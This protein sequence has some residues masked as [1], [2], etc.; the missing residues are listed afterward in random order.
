MGSALKQT[1]TPFATVGEPAPPVK[2]DAS[3]VNQVERLNAALEGRYVVERELGRG[4]MA[5]VYLA[6]DARHEREVAIKVLLPELSASIGADRFEREIRLAAKLQHPHILGLF[7]SGSANGLL[8]YVMPFVKGE[9]LRDRMDREGQLPVDDAILIILEVADA[10][11]HAHAQGIVHRDIKPENIMLSGGHALVADFGIARAATD[12]GVQKLTQTGMAIGTP[13]YM[14]PEQAGGEDVGPAAD[15]YSLACVLYEMLAGEPPFTGKTPMSIMARHAMEQ[16]PSIRIV[17]SAVS[18]EVEAAIYAGMGK[19]PAD[20]PRTAQ[21]F[22]E[23]IGMPMAMTASL[24]AVTG[25]TGMRRVASGS[26]LLQRRAQARARRPWY[27][28]ASRITAAI[29]LLL[30]L[31]I[32][33]YYAA[34]ARRGPVDENARRVAVLYFTD[35]SKAQDLGSL[36]DGLTEGLINSLG[37]A[38]SITVIS[39]T[40][41]ER[42]RGSELPPDSIARA[43]RAGYLV[44]GDVDREGKNVAVNVRLEDRSG[45]K[46]QAKS[47]RIAESDPLAMRDSLETAVSEL[48]KTT[49]HEEIQL[50][51]ERAGTSKQAAWLELQR[52]EQAR[53]GIAAL[54]T[55]GD[56]AAVNRAVAVTDSI[57]AH[58]E[59]L[60]P[61]WAEPVTRRAW[62]AYQRSRSVGRDPA[63]IRKWVDIATQHAGRALAMDA[64]SPDALEVRGTAKYWSWLSNLETDASKKQALLLDAK[65]DL[66]HATQLNPKQ[67]SAFATL[68]SLYYQVPDATTN[69]AYLAATKAYDADEFL[70]NAN[71]VINR[72]FLG[73]YDLGSFDRADQHC[74]LF[75][76]RFPQDYRSKRCRLFMLSTPRAP[77]LDLTAARRLADSTVAMRAPKDSLLER[78]NTNLLI[79]AAMA[80]ASAQQPA[81]ADSARRVVKASIGDAQVDPNRDLTYLAAFVYAQLGDES[82]AVRMVKEYL[83]ANPQRARSLRDEP[84]WGFKRLEGNAQFRQV[85]GTRG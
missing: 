51:T 83:A 40:G 70:A 23:I 42:F 4:G 36:A 67:A 29:T 39:R 75:V 16:V 17:R 27:T 85:I 80:R 37:N 20:R 7:D 12:A 82:D 62:L 66:E 48:I 73:A 18:E 1:Q 68:A 77:V 3:T 57:L 65:A 33:G 11:A 64:E 74:R 26:Q 21:E 9:S 25:P 60:D 71:V 53:K 34:Q 84:W 5:T 32:G 38:S 43:L 47:F 56:T 52:G 15:I 28:R 24:R 76:S 49:L 78:W 8:Y 59:S 55:K 31:I 63:L 44:R 35:Q 79:A 14:S 19:V 54:V 45:T 69:D 2:Y 30:A 41:V 58:A 6:K 50:R 46:I 10:L 72:L 61:R 81:L 13:M 22:A